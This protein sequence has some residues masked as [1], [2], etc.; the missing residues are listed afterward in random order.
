MKRWERAIRGLWDLIA[1]PGMTWRQYLDAI[2]PECIQQAEAEGR[3]GGK[4]ECPV[5]GMRSHSAASADDCCEPKLAG[6]GTRRV[7]DEAVVAKYR[8]RV[9]GR[10]PVNHSALLADLKGRAK[11]RGIGVTRLCR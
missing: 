2:P 10:I 9:P 7:A 6:R 5:C 11:E 3:V 4:Y 1:P 8:D